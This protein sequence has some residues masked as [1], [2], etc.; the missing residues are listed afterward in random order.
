MMFF[1][2]IFSNRN[3]RML[4]RMTTILKKIN[5][6]ETNME[7]LSDKQLI[8][9]TSEF[10]LRIQDGET[11]AQLLPEA[12]AVVREASKR[13]F[14][15]RHFDVQILGGI[16]LNE[17]CVAEMRTGE[18]KTLTATLS[19]YLNALNG[20]GVHIVTVNDYL[21]KRDAEN[22]RP[23]FEFLGMTVGMNLAG[24][25]N[26]EKHTAY[27][28]D[29][30]YGTNNE[31]GFDYLRDNMVFHPEERVQRKLHYAI[32]DEVDSI[33]IDEARTPLIISGSYED[34]SDLYI[35][36]DKLIRNVIKKNKEDYGIDC[37][38]EGYFSIDAKSRQVYLT[39]SGLILLENLMVNEQLVTDS[40]SIYSPSNIIL[41]HHANSALRA[42]LLFFRDVDYIVKNGE[43]MIVDEHTGRTMPGR[44]W[45]DGLHQALEAKE[46]VSIQSDNQTLASIT[47]QNYFRLYEKLAGMTGTAATEAFELSTIYGLDTVVIPTNRPMIRQDMP[48]LVYITEK[49]KINA[50]IADIR[51]C[52][53][54]GQPVL[55]GTISIEKSETI[56]REL[57][58]SGIKH[59]VLNA[60]FHA[61]EADIIAQA[62]KPGSVTIATNMA[63]RGTDIILGGNWQ[64]DLNKLDKP[65]IKQIHEIKSAWKIRH[66]RVVEA[67][68]LHIIGTERHE[69]RRI[70]NQLRGRSG[71]QGDAG[72]S[73]F[74]LSMEDTLMRI[75]AS[76]RISNLM[77]RLQMKK[78]EAIEHPWITKSI[79]NAQRKVENRN[80]DIRKQLLE[81]DDVANNQRRTI[82]SQR[83]ELL[84]LSDISETIANIRKDV[85]IRVMHVYIPLHSVKEMWNIEGLQKH[86]KDDFDLDFT[87]NRIEKEQTYFENILKQSL[88][89]Y[90]YKEK[91]VGIE[92]MR[93]I[94]KKVMLQTIDF[95]WKE[96]LA[97]IDYLRQGI[98]FRGYAQVD[99]KQEYKRES[100]N[101]F[102]DM[103][104]AVK[105]EVISTLS[106][107]QFSKPLE[108][109]NGCKANQS[110]SNKSFNKNNNKKLSEHRYPFFI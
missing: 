54:R 16:A 30:T 34:S 60:K 26:K 13:V 47:F 53:N 68:G 15:M 86:L 81:Y 50:I 9:K 23:L 84:M 21:A 4:R 74:Y 8:A 31:Y 65:N 36:I 96:H 105:Y 99:P 107:L 25:P 38:T 1:K 109:W 87:P 29:I 66:Q 108:H 57:K 80:F 37:N 48:D 89:Q 22:N 100:F 77:K 24:L 42:H 97:A 72:S 28:A 59:Q 43:I 106:K 69:S 39:E 55:V 58:K 71:R 35:K 2:K 104:E 76:Q 40:Q 32:I 6:I 10:R 110:V 11:I 27:A 62:G 79:A 73:R 75:F 41:M 17:R 14:N 85:L 33:L 7:R 19:A 70:D 49:E 78:G 101:M 52:I 94:E 83:N 95:F 103:L 93:K 56:S 90:Q 98:H 46:N 44:R 18:G 3:D 5:A 91:I 20:K 51:R 61:I 88:E 12:F 64:S 102:S 67:G 63:G 92:V 82:Y 45:S